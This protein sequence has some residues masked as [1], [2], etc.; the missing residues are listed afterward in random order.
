MSP[1]KSKR[2]KAPK[3][4]SKI[5]AQIAEANEEALLLE[6]AEIYDQA[7]VGLTFGSEPVVVYDYQ[8]LID[9]LVAS[10]ES[11]ENA[12]EHIDYN[13]LGSI[14]QANYPIVTRAIDEA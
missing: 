5:R 7:I 9:A 11:E 12:V 8:L 6:P 1:S 10:G 14:G 13:I 4:V 2:R 3:P